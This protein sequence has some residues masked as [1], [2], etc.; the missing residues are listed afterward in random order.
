M[1]TAQGVSF[2]ILLYLEAFY[3]EIEIQ[4]V[5]LFEQRH[6]NFS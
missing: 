1:T 4:K 5:L 2:I 6:V 3:K